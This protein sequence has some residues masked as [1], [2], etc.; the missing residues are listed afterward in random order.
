MAND[1]VAIAASMK[2]IVFI[3]DENSASKEKL[4]DYLGRELGRAKVEGARS[5]A[6]DSLDSLHVKESSSSKRRME[7]SPFG[8]TH[9]GCWIRRS[10]WICCRRP[11]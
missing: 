8:S 4:R 3:S 6:I 10:S 7:D 9:S 2:I 5:T 11:V 1:I